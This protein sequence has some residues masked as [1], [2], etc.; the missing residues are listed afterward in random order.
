MPDDIS[1]IFTAFKKSNGE[2]LNKSNTCTERIVFNTNLY[3]NLP[4]ERLGMSLQRYGRLLQYGR[5]D[6]T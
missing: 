1:Q 2:T 3:T 6:A 5:K 4:L